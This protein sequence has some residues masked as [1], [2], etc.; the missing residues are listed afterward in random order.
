MKVKIFVTLKNGILDPQ[1]RA[2]QQSLQTLGFSTVEEVRIGKF[3]ELDLN[4]TN[5]ASAE[6]KIKS[7]CEKLLAN[8]V[9]ED[10][11]YEILET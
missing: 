3:M 7:M 6:N 9:I 4:E 10:Y 1:G 11:R 8:T 5:T 2:I